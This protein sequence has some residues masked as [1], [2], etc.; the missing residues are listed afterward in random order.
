MR[1]LLIISGERGTGKTSLTASF[2]V[3]AERPAVADY[4]S[5]VSGDRILDRLVVRADR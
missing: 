5:R 3:L 4:S 2:A 1:E